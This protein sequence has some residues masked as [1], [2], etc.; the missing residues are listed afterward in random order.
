VTRRLALLLSALTVSV[1]AAV[2]LFVVRFDSGSPESG[3]NWTA[4]W[5]ADPPVVSTTPGG[6]LE[7]A[8]MRM[9]ED[10]YKS[11]RRTWWGIYLGETV[12]HIQVAATYRYAVP[13]ADPAWEIVTHGPICVV[14]APDVRPSLPVAID[15]GT[16]LEKTESGW[17]R[18]DKQLNLEELRRS[19]STELENRANDAARAAL[20]RDA[21]RRT[22]G[23]FVEHWLAMRGQWHPGVFSAVKVYFPDE[24]DEALRNELDMP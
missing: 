24:V 15:T 23:E 5:H 21:S 13:L 4:E 12:S 7:A 16:M 19:L 2:V 17:A 1:I 20:A 6:L 9:V 3:R 14:I 11:D 10:F 22:I 8:T 18:F